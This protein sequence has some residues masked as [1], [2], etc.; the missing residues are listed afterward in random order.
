M[1]SAVLVVAVASSAFQTL[2]QTG[3]WPPQGKTGDWKKIGPWGIGDDVAASGEAGTLADAVSPASNPNLI[4]AGG[5]NNG[6]SSGVLKSTDRGK[7]WTVT[8]TTSS[9]LREELGANDEL[10]SSGGDGQGVDL[11]VEREHFDY[12]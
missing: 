11:L 8:A 7:T 10:R 1:H 9:C 2:A 5:Q 12:D 6:A 4:Y 3:K